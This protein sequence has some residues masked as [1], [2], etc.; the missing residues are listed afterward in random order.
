MKDNR[1]SHLMTSHVHKEKTEEL[2]LIKIGN[3]SINGNDERKDIFG[4]FAVTNIK[5]KFTSKDASTQTL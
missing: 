2:D 5:V 3:I 4:Q 1:L